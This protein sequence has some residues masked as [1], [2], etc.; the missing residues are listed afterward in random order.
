MTAEIRPFV[1]DFLREAG[2]TLTTRPLRV[3]GDAW[4]IDVSV[5]H[6]AIFAVDVEARSTGRTRLVTPDPPVLEA[7]LVTGAAAA[8]REAHG[9]RG[10]RDSSLRGPRTH[11]VVVVQDPDGFVVR[12]R[13]DG[14][15]AGTCSSS[16]DAARLASALDHPVETLIA[17]AK[18]NR[19]R[20]VWTG[21]TLA[22]LVRG[23]VMTLVL[24][25]TVAGIKLSRHAGSWELVLGT[26][27]GVL[28]VVVG[29]TW[30]VVRMRRGRRLV[31]D[32]LDR[33]R[34][35]APTWRCLTGPG[36]AADLTA[37]GV[38]GRLPARQAE[39]TLVEAPTGLE[40]W[41]AGE[42]E[43]L[44]HVPWMTI[45]SVEAEPVPA[46]PVCVLVVRTAR[47]GRVPVILMRDPAGSQRGATAQVTEEYAAHLLQRSRALA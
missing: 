8:W 44:L 41:R 22:P 5:R 16:T 25:G 26:S 14:A 15:W 34:P 43:P 7:F 29:A 46:S 24:V 33:A 18:E 13:S 17:A 6:D 30:V 23:L 42:A 1:A 35:G 45:A 36:F 20:P 12:R 32:A 40:L 28:V 37:L 2:H 10:L 21:S 38:A 4:S 47:G 9:L 11:V 3:E 39:V 19:G 27:L 31:Q